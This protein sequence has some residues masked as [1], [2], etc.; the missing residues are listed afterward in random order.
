MNTPVNG[1]NGNANNNKYYYF[2][3]NE[4]FT[5]AYRLFSEGKKPFEVAIELGIRARLC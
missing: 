3:S 5:Q 2:H 4:K 1:G